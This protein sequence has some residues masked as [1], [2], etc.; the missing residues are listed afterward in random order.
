MGQQLCVFF[1]FWFYALL[2]SDRTHER[3][4]LTVMRQNKN[5]NNWNKCSYA[6]ELKCRVTHE[7]W[8]PADSSKSSILHKW[9]K[10]THRYWSK[11]VCLIASGTSTPCRTCVQTSLNQ[12]YPDSKTVFFRK[13]QSYQLCLRFHYFIPTKP[14]LYCI[15]IWF[16]TIY[17]TS[18]I[19]YQHIYTARKM[20]NINPSCTLK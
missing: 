9:V 14:S 13:T 16:I 12:V 8:Q 1:S 19:L 10:S 20:C 11:W 18:N 2:R 6:L 17:C 3:I 4:T 15:Q 7:D 5:Q